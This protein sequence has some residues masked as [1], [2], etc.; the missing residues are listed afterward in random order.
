MFGN[1]G[2]AEI[3]VLLVVGLVVLGPERLPDAARWIARAIR[4]VKDFAKSAEKQL[5]DDFGS[6]FE[7]FREPLQQINS[8]RGVTPRAL[9]TKHLLDGDESLFTGDFEAAAPNTMASAGGDGARAAAPTSR[10]EQTPRSAAPGAD[11]ALAWD[12]DAT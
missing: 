3:L 7:E 4:K 6:D 2:W 9:V 11:S 12:V 10:P 5:Q 8:L 1:V